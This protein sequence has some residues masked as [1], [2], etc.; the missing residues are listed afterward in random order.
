MKSTIAASTNQLDGLTATRQIHNLSSEMKNVPII[1]MT[2]QAMEH[3]RK[4]SHEAGMNDHE[5]KPLKPDVLLQSIMQWISLSRTDHE[6][7]TCIKDSDSAG[8]LELPSPSL[9]IDEDVV[10]DMEVEVALDRLGD[11]KKLY[12]RLLRDFLHNNRDLHQRLTESV[13]NKRLEEAQYLVHTLQGESG[14]IGAVS[15]QEAA[16]AMEEALLRHLT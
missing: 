9:S 2:A 7:G 1:A 10:V 11:N 8:A 16:Q 5:S 15:I 12:L 4:K 6:P 3:D 14:S 13:T